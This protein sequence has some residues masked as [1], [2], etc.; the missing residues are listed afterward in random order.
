[1]AD[2]RLAWSNTS[3]R[4]F[5]GRTWRPSEPHEVIVGRFVPSMW[6][7]VGGMKA[8]LIEPGK[9][10]ERIDV[11]DDHVERCDKPAAITGTDHARVRFM[12]TK[13]HDINLFFGDGTEPNPVVD[14]LVAKANNWEHPL[15]GTVAIAG[16]GECEDADIPWRIAQRIEALAPLGQVQHPPPSV[17]R[18][19]HALRIWI[20]GDV[21]EEDLSR[22]HSLTIG[23]AH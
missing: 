22:Y 16:R 18:D 23:D 11:P 17:D 8:M 5:F 4:S 15:T 9:R 13:H 6:G 14:S 2:R 7:T 21:I 19:P 20:T 3:I 12:T 10:P 1:M